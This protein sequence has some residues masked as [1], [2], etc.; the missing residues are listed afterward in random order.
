MD[1]QGVKTLVEDGVT[2]QFLLSNLPS[3]SALPARLRTF[4]DL[5][6]NRTAVCQLLAPVP[7][8]ME[9]SVKEVLAPY[10]RAL[11]REDIGSVEE[12]MGFIFRYVVF[13]CCFSEVVV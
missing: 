3:L 13:V 6:R 10:L 8:G 12:R 7:Q 1:G 4:E 9:D 2:L 11:G 5:R